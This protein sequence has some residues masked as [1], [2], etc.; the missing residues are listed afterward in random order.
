MKIAILS[1]IAWRTPPRKYGPWELVAHHIAEGLVKE[2]FEITLFAT[3]D[4][5]TRGTLDAV[6][7]KGY[8]EDKEMDAKVG[9]YLHIG[10]LM[11][12][13]KKFDLIHNHFDFMPLV[14]SP[15]ISTPMV[16]TIHGFSSQKIIDVYQR[17]NHLNHFVSI[18]HADRS[19]RLQYAANIYHGIEMDDF[20]FN[21]DPD[22]YLLYF[23]RIHPEKGTSEAIEIALKANLPLLISG[24][25]QD[26][27][28]YRER[29]V[30]FLSDNIKYLGVA[31]P[32]QRNE[33]LGHAMALLHPISFDEPFG[34]S[35]IESMACGTPVIAYPRGSMKELILHQKTGFLVENVV[36]AVEAIEKINSIDRWFC[37]DWC[38][39]QF[40]V[41]R[42]IKEY[43]EL[44]E[45]V[46]IEA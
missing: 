40:S 39:S 26:Q 31:G 34:L 27:N 28:Y 25:V 5:I 10:N 37:R 33:L 32:D 19:D 35:V 18:S 7:P 45:S 46:L 16:T 42:M 6:I 11:E 2:G 41:D 8:E 23:G 14:Y 44:Y 21:K 9:E 22:N 17:Y 4:S 3:G 38:R 36:E 24:P 1:S 12:K 30:P 15:L 43:I 13:A 29:V 20:T